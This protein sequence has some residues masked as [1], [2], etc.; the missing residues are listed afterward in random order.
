MRRRKISRPAKAL[1]RFSS[2][3]YRLPQKPAR[4]V[5]DRGAGIA[6]GLPAAALHHQSRHGRAAQLLSDLQWRGRH[7]LAAATQA[8]KGGKPEKS[9]G[10]PEQLDRQGRRLSP[11]REPAKPAGGKPDNERLTRQAEPRQA[12]PKRRTGG[13]GPK[14]QSPRKPR[15]RHSKPTSRSRWTK[16]RHRPG[17]GAAR[18]VKSRHGW[19]TP[20]TGKSDAPKP[21]PPEQP[22]KTDAAKTD[23]AKDQPAKAEPAKEDKPAGDEGGKPAAAKPAGEASPRRPKPNHRRKRAESA[24]VSGP[25]RFRRNARAA[26]AP[27]TSTAAP[28]DLGTG[29]QRVAR[30]ARALGGARAASAAPPP[31][32]PRRSQHRRPPAPRPRQ[33]RRRRRFRN[34]I[35]L[36][37]RGP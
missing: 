6:A 23:A 32:R 19:A 22:G 3:L 15:V 9:G 33:G 1:P 13:V 24:P 12:E 36:P 18:H 35:L 16:A 31:A 27:A 34:R 28:H 21:T 30:R 37:V 2:G 10:E 4:T 7:P 29:G 17:S 26:A 11:P 5:E 14:P 25:I 20:E 8:G